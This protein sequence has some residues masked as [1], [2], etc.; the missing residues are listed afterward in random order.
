MKTIAIESASRSRLI[1]H[2]SALVRKVL[3]C[4]A[5]LVCLVAAPR[6]SAAIPGS[7]DPTFDPG[8]GLDLSKPLPVRVIF[9]LSDGS[10]LLGGIFTNYNGVARTALAKILEDG[11][12]DPGFVPPASFMPG[13]T[14]IWSVSQQTDGKFVVSGITGSPFHAMIARLNPDGSLDPTFTFVPRS[15]AF[16]MAVQARSDGLIARPQVLDRR[17]RA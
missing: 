8:T 17:R 16:G 2:S 4:L 6:V 1:A 3:Y 15:A 5:A 11:A 9:P 12:L 7:I 14:E 13:Y 10:F